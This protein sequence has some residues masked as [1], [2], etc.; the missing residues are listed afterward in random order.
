MAYLY[1]FLFVG[2]F[3]LIAQLIFDKTKLTPGHIVSFCVVLGVILSFFGLYDYLIKYLPG[4]ASILI[5][6]YGH[7]LYSSG[8]EGLNEGTVLNAF[9]KL[10]AKSSATLSFAIFMGLICSIF[11]KH[12]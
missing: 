8:L 1:S 2:G 11:T 6:N 9:M 7:L 12:E 3:C 10:M 5:T 4:G